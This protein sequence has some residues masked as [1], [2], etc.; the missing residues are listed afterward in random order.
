MMIIN[1]R[2]IGVFQIVIG[3]ELRYTATKYLVMVHVPKCVL[4]IRLRSES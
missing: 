1:M 2:I 4:Y 3:L